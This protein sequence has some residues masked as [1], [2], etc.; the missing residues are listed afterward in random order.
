MFIVKGAEQIFT[1]FHLN[2]GVSLIFR[3]V[4]GPISRIKCLYMHS[5][6]D[7]NKPNI[8]GGSFGCL[9]ENQVRVSFCWEKGSSKKSCETYWA[10]Y[11][12]YACPSIQNTETICKVY[13]TENMWWNISN[14]LLSNS[15]T[16][17]KIGFCDFQRHIFP[18]GVWGNILR[19][20]NYPLAKF[21]RGF[22]I[23]LLGISFEKSSPRKVRSDRGLKRNQGTRTRDSWYFCR[24][25]FDH[26]LAFFGK[27]SWHWNIAL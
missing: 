9:I 19:W 24:L 12:K 22:N 4:Q 26:F 7:W 25:S 18:I 2:F 27:L 3:L 13:V 20:R 8:S 15:K 23:F 21:T 11:G 5:I 6:K 14:L 16:R 10:Y 1:C 17:S